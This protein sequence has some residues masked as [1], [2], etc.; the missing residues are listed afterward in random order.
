MR[1]Y[2]MGYLLTRQGNKDTRCIGSVLNDSFDND[3]KVVCLVLLAKQEHN[4][5]SRYCEKAINKQNFVTNTFP[6]HFICFLVFR[7]AI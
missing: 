1:T 4:I 2:C 7:N 6:A 5:G 3:D